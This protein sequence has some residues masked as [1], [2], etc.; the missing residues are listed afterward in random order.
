MPHKGIFAVKRSDHMA[1]KRDSYSDVAAVYDEMTAD[2]ALQ[3]FYQYCRK[4]LLQAIS[5]RIGRINC[6]LP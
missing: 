6:L 2:P 3:K 4:L 1:E 5:E